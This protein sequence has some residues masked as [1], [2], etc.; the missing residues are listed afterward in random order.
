WVPT[1]V[2]WTATLLLFGWTL[3]TIL[4]S[5]AVAGFVAYETVHYRIHFRCPRGEIEEYLRSRHLVHHDYYPTR[6]FAVPSAVWDLIFG[7]EAMGPEMAALCESTRSKPPLS[8][9][10]NL[11]KLAGYIRPW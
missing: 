3:G 6:C 11:Y 8:V 10:T 7:T 4:L 1:A 2:V 5:G 9:R